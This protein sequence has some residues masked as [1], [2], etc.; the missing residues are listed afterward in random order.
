MISLFLF[1]NPCATSSAFFHWFCFGFAVSHAPFC[2]WFFDAT[3]FLSLCFCIK[4]CFSSKPTPKLLSSP[5]FWWQD[6]LFQIG[7]FY[8]GLCILA[9]L[10]SNR[11]HAAN[12]PTSC[13]HKSIHCS[14]TS[15]QV[16]FLCHP[17]TP[18]HRC[19][20]LAICKYH[21]RC[22]Y[23]TCTSLRTVL[24]L[25]LSICRSQISILL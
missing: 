20:H 3:L 15:A 24:H 6:I 2:S 12:H 25:V 21:S 4:T 23:H 10:G 1:R 5:L 11:L 14:K 13:Q 8:V 19:H 22:V 18:L 9:A 17:W 16:R 7:F